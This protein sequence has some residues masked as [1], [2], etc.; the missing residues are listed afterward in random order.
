MENIENLE[1]V[2]SIAGTNFKKG[3]TVNTKGFYDKGFLQNFAEL[4]NFSAS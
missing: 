4:Y 3:L 2:K 1:S